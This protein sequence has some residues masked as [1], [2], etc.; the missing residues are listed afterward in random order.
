MRKIIVI[1]AFAL[2]SLLSACGAS[3]LKDES[4][5]GGEGVLRLEGS[6]TRIEVKDIHLKVKGQEKG[7]EVVFAF[8][9]KGS[10]VELKGPQELLPEIKAAFSGDRLSIQAAG[11][12]RYAVE[13]GLTIT[14]YD[15]PYEKLERLSLAGACEARS[16]LETGLGSYYTFYNDGPASPQGLAQGNSRLEVVLSGASILKVDALKAGAEL[17]MELSGASRL[18]AEHIQAGRWKLDMSGA[19]ALLAQAVN[20][21]EADWHIGGASQLEIPPRDGAGTAASLFAVLTGASQVKAYGYPVQKATLT[22]S[23]SALL[24]CSVTDVLGGSITG[25]STVYYR[26]NPTLATHV[27]SSS[28]LEKR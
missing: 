18:E 14:F 13:E 21:E 27:G 16:E 3:S 23:G 28:H 24:E 9:G 1:L 2:L 22:L 12:K 17:K 26:G 8:D 25:G 5:G 15:Q 4:K 20:A 10:R 7:P 11:G 19:S 6:A